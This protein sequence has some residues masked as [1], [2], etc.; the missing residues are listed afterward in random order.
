MFQLWQRIDENVVNDDVGNNY[1]L[2]WVS[3]SPVD[4]VGLRV[5]WSEMKMD[6]AV[7]MDT[8]LQM[9]IYLSNVRFSESKR[10]YFCSSIWISKRDWISKDAHFKF[11]TQ[12]N[13]KKLSFL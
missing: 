2:L 12:N 11:Y 3:D 13:F 7:T 1:S 4:E 5:S 8:V 10:F 9:P 6:A